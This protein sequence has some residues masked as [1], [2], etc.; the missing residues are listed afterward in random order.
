MNFPGMPNLPFSAIPPLPLALSVANIAS[1][2]GFGPGVW[3][4]FDQNG[5]P[6]ILADSVVA[7]ECKQDWMISSAPVEMGGFKT[8]NKVTTPF[9]LKITINK[10][11]MGADRAAFISAIETVCAD[12]NLYSIVTPEKT[13]LNINF[14][15]YDYRRTAINGNGLLGADMWAQE[16]RQTAGSMFSLQTPAS[17]DGASPVNGGAVQTFAPTQSQTTPPPNFGISG[18]GWD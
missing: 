11:G 4:I 16:I 9:D 1:L 2:L 5:S 13:Y 6:V 8:Y 12:V 10:S 3:G 14:C 7:L 18:Q 17:P 15:H